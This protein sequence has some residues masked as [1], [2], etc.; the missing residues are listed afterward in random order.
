[1]NSADQNEELEGL[2]AQI[3]ALTARIFRLEQRLGF[4]PAQPQAPLAPRVTAPPPV[5][6]SPG[7]P[8]SRPVPISKPA[9]G[10]PQQPDLE[11]KI[12]Q[13]WLNRIGIVAVLIGIAYFLKLAFDNRWIGPAGRVGIGLL[14]GIVL[15]LWSERFRNRGYQVF[16]YSLKAIGIGTM[17]LSLWASFQVYHLV[18]AAVA[19]AAMALVTTAT[20]VLALTQDSEL[21]G[22]FAILG[23]YSTPLLVST[24]QNNEVTLFSYLAL[25]DVAVVAMAA[26][27]PWRR[28]VWGSVAGTGLLYW[29]WFISYY[30]SSQRVRTVFFTLLFGAIFAS[31][32]LVARQRRSI[33]KGGASITLTA[34]PLL[35]ALGTF[36]GLYFMHPNELGMLAWY[37]LG[38][39][40]LYLAL[41]IQ[42]GRRAT[43]AESVLLKLLYISIAIAFLTVA[44]PLRLQEFSGY[45]ITLAWVVEAAALLGASQ[46]V[47]MP[48]LLYLGNVALALGVLRLLLI[49][50]A[51][52]Q[53]LLLNPRFGL[54][55]LIL[56]VLA[57]IVRATPKDS[58][59]GKV[60]AA[61]CAIAF[62]VL[63]LLALSWEASDYFSRQSVLFRQQTGITFYGYG[64]FQLARDFSYSAIWLGYGAVLMIAGFRRHSAFTRWQALVLIGVTIAKVFI[65][66]VHQLERVYRV[67]SF[68][69]LGAVLLAISFVYQRNWLRLGA[70]SPEEKTSAESGA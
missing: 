41:G 60:Y 54:F 16:S 4:E 26:V 40:A 5:S 39:G 18:P 22:V 30:S 7:A 29:G 6:V 66:D 56:A 1:V 24:G 9:V 63:A 34:L 43:Q 69:A 27:K 52:A 12:G 59:G 20:I 58:E 10:R 67:L 68:I 51:E 17:Y 21:L 49:D 3:A 65:Y 36:G 33:F 11:K 35:A 14:I 25:L 8:V 44:I 47:H 45:W 64:Q 15:V 19:F 46:R 50:N 28:L 53:R 70:R 31:L 38:L 61:A 42:I 55:L 23:G 62:N 13:Y 2:K 32:P 48:L 37:S 57:G